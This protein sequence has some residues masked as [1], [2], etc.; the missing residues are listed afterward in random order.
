MT[1]KAGDEEGDAERQRYSKSERGE[2]KKGMELI[3]G[4]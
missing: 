1:R 3:N 4:I 2:G